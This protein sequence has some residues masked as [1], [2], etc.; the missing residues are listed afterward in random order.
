MREDAFE[1]YKTIIECSLDLVG[2]DIPVN[3]INGLH[4]TFVFVLSTY[5]KDCIVDTDRHL[6]SILLPARDLITYPPYPYYSVVG[7]FN[8]AQPENIELFG[9]LLSDVLIGAR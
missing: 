8:L 2:F 3:I 6:L 7:Q 9:L 1:E 4:P 5:R